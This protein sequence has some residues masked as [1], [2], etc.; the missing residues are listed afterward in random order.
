MYI[1]YS[2]DTKAGGAVDSS[3]R[4]ERP[5]KEIWIDLRAGQSLAIRNLTRTRAGFSIQECKEDTARPFFVVSC[6]R[7]RGKGHTLKHK[8][9][10]L[11]IRK[12]FFTVRVTEHQNKLSIE[13]CGVYTLGDIRK[14][15]GHNPGQTAPGGLT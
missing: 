10:H 5:Y 3:G 12:Q 1:E 6:D 8:S 2:N 13:V 9:F 14:P 4:R 7:A 15:S 11:N